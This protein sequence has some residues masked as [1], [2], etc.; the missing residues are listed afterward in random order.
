MADATPQADPVAAATAPRAAFL[1]PGQGAQFVG[2]GRRL[3]EQFPAARELFQRA[4]DALGYG[5]TQ[6]CLEG[7]AEELNSTIR[8][9]PA[10]F[11][12]S[13]AAVEALRAEQP[14]ALERCQAAAGLS[15]GEYTALVFAGAMEFEPALR[16]VQARGAAMQAAADATPSG[17]VSLLGLEQ[18]AVEALCREAAG[19]ELLQVANLLCPGNIVVSGAKGACQRV[20]DMAEGAGAMK[21]IPLTV[22]GAFHTPLMK[23]ADERLAEALAGVALRAPRIPVVSNVDARPHSDPEEIR[24]LLVKQVLEPVQWEATLRW[25]L[26]A[27]FNEFYEVGPGRVLQGLLK[28][29]DRK[30]KCSGV[31]C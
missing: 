25:L 12:T 7:P 10:L 20:A 24:G 9:Q 14:A 30:A 13:L 21:A 26:A 19:G 15:L 2:M 27:G 29:V 1:F 11:V 6:I 22:A 16:V 8:S 5:L 31:E 18:P 28:R 23:P 3:I 17:M 4:D